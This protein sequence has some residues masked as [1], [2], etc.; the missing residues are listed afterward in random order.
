MLLDVYVRDARATENARARAVRWSKS[1]SMR[2]Y[3]SQPARL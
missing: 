3:V 1:N 2:R